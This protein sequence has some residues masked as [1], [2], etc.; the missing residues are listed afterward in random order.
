MSHG[1]WGM[2]MGRLDR[3][4]ENRTLS[5]EN[6]TTDTPAPRLVHGVVLLRFC[7][8]M[9]GAG[10]G[11]VSA[12][13]DP[14]TDDAR[15]ER[16]RGRRTG[17]DG[18]SAVMGGRG[19]RTAHKPPQNARFCT[20]VRSGSVCSALMGGQQGRSALFRGAG[21]G[22]CHPPPTT[23]SHAQSAHCEP[24]TTPRHPPVA[25]PVGAGGGAVPRKKR[26]MPRLAEEHIFFFLWCASLTT[27]A[28]P[29]KFEKFFVRT[30]SPVKYQ[31]FITKFPQNFF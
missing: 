5:T 26:K 3:V 1:S 4:A 16:W 7:E 18:C 17:E 6:D 8:M 24:F 14:P 13:I 21:E 19:A 20:I 9:V 31:P 23:H 25:R 12:L 29:K 30:D 2:S 28:T 27:D 15:I 10:E 22:V 11:A